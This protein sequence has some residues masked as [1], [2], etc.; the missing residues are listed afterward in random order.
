[1]GEPSCWLTATREMLINRPA[2]LTIEKIAAD[3]GFS[4]AWLRMVARGAISDPGILKI[5]ALRRYLQNHSA[6][7]I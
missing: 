1:M 7:G 5:Q 4:A 2:S 6:R 3:L